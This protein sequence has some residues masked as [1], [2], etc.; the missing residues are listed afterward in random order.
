MAY[1]LHL[2]LAQCL[3]VLANRIAESFHTL[4]ID[5]QHEKVS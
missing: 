4:G 2:F 5:N 1:V 3:C